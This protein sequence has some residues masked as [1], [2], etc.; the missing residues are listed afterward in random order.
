MYEKLVQQFPNAGK[1][2]KIY[3]EQEVVTNYL[4]LEK[5]E[6]GMNWDFTKEV[7]QFQCAL[8]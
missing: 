7:G 1:Y 5:A 8:M 6:V 3:I 2:W 4:L